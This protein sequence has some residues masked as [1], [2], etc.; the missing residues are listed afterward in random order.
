MLFSFGVDALILTV[1]VGLSG[2]FSAIEIAVFSISKVKM[3]KLVSSGS[4]NADALSRMKRNPR[5]LLTTILIGNNLVNISAASIAAAIALDIFQSDY[6]IAVS[7]GLLTLVVLVFGE[8][9]PKSVA[10]KHNEF[11]ALNSVPF[12]NFLG[13]I[14]MPV[15]FV[16]ERITGFFT[17]YLGVDVGDQLLTE[18]EVKTVVSLSAEEGSIKKEEKE[19]IHR[20]FRLNDVSVEEIMTPRSEMMAV[21]SGT[22]V[23]KIPKKTMNQYSRLPV[24]KGDMDEIIGIFHAR[25]YLGSASRK[26]SS[27][28]VDE[29]MRPPVFVYSV[30]KIDKLLKEFQKRS[31]HMAI[32]VDEYGGTIGL[33]TIEDVLEEIVGEIEDETDTLPII[34]KVREN[35]YLVEGD[36]SVQR[37]NTV[38]GTSIAPKGAETV[39]GVVM[40]ALEKMPR[41][42]D[43]VQVDGVKITVEKMGG[44]K[45]EMVRVFR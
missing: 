17:G 18:E 38:L 11:I 43:S 44:P 2:Y 31:V 36:A 42:K 39:A 22:L 5:K 34:K 29:F 37:L 15:I 12:I 20:I 23:K 26:R 32:V 35:E 45:I 7:T 19:M 16:L 28:P 40:N 9:I 3:K 21:E 1:L 30:K 14:F 41:E 25:D 27:R 13:M 24:F 6:G 10:L 33:A 8:I 4:G